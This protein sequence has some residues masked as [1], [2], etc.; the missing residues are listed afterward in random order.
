MKSSNKAFSFDET[1]CFSLKTWEEIFSSV[2]ICSIE[3]TKQQ[4]IK[5]LREKSQAQDKI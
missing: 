5:L 3:I 1:G 2:H 4:L